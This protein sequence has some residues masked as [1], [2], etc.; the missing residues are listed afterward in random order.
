MS[1]IVKFACYRTE[2]QLI[3]NLKQ[4]IKKEIKVLFYNSKIISSLAVACICMTFFGNAFAEVTTRGVSVASSTYKSFN[5]GSVV[6]DSELEEPLDLLEDF[7]PSVSITYGQHD[8]VRRRS[9]L[10]EEDGKFTVTP[11]LSYRKDIGRHKLLLSYSGIY[12][13]HD[14]LTAEDAESNI[15]NAKLGLDINR[16]LDLDVFFGTGETFED[17]GISGSRAFNQ[18]IIIEDE[19]PDIVDMEFYGADLVYGRDFSRLK[20]VIGFEKEEFS[21]ANNFQGSDLPEA[22]RD[23]ERDTIHLDIGYDIGSKTTLFARLQEIEID[24]ARDLNSLDSEEKSYLIGL[25]WRPT[26]ALSGVAGFGNTEKDFVDPAREDFDGSTY[27]VNLN[28]AWK[29]FSTFALNFSRFVEEPGDDISDYFV[30]DLIGASWNHSLTERLSF[31]LYAKTIDDEFNNGRI[32]EFTD[33]GLNVDYIFRKWL[34]LGV[35]YGRIERESNQP[36]IP[37]TDKYYGFSIKSDLRKTD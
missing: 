26:Y 20:A 31:G 13:L 21:F 15:F 25:R 12:T 37:Y 5:S 14:D 24:Y 34:T 8:N 3:Y 1:V 29:P 36:D 19:T 16:R 33:Y 18:S 9:D 17:R 27:Y 2:K 7:Y 32:D 22:S 11:E 30:S 6:R 35:Y 4:N 28:Y 10:D 23:R